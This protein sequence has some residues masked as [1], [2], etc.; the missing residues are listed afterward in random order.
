MKDELVKRKK[1]LPDFIMERTELQHDLRTYSRVFY[2][3]D[4]YKHIMLQLFEMATNRYTSLRIH[5]QE[6]IF[7]ALPFFPYS[8]KIFMPHILDLL[9]KDPD[10]FHEAHKVYII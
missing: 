3:T 8:R 4:Y 5:S 7:Q 6:L 1:V 10:E 2:L 9:T